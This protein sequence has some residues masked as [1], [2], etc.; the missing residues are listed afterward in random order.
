M[1]DELVRD[2][3]KKIENLLGYQDDEEGTVSMCVDSACSLSADIEDLVNA[4]QFSVIRC[5]TC[6]EVI[7]KETC[8]Q[9]YNAHAVCP[10]CRREFQL[11][12][13]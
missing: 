9:N 7:S 12:E 11:K 5:P 6:N 10:S 3:R 2:L 1:I 13:V 8:M 4:V